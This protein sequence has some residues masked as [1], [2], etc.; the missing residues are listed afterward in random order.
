MSKDLHPGKTRDAGTDAAFWRNAAL[1]LGLDP[2][3][4]AEH[5]H[6]GDT[7]ELANDLADEVCSGTKRATA[8]LVAE[9]KAEGEPIPKVDDHWIVIDGRGQPRAIIQT[10]GVRIT[11]FPEVDEAFAWDEGEGDRSLGW[12]RVNLTR[13]S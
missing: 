4:P 3:S 11:P 8:G 10:R 12:W 13:K 5:F 1:S 7:V 9:M 2:A 6:F